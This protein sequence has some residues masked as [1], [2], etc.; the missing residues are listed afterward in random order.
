MKVLVFL[1]ASTAR[2]VTAT[3]LRLRATEADV[4]LLNIGLSCAWKKA[5]IWENWRSVVNTAMLEK[6]MP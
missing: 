4:K 5:T 2:L 3:I 6:S 1:E